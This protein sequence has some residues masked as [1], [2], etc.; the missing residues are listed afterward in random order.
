MTATARP[1]PEPPAP[2]ARC[3]ASNGSCTAVLASASATLCTGSYLGD[4]TTCGAIS[5]AAPTSPANTLEDISLTG[6]IVALSSPDDGDA[7][8]AL[9][10]PF[11]FYGNT[12][13]GVRV[14]SNGYLSFGPSASTP[15]NQDPIPDATTPNDGI[16]ALWDDLHL[17]VVGHVFSE[18]RG[19]APYRRFI[20]QWNRVARFD[21]PAIDVLVYPEDTFQV[22]LYET[23]NAVEFRYGALN[24]TTPW[25]ATVGL[26]N[27][28]GTLATQ[29]PQSVV[30]GGN[31]ALVF[32][33]SGMTC[34]QP[35][36]AAAPP[37]AASSLPTPIAS[38]PAVNTRAMALPAPPHPAP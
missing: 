33:P 1:A 36:G 21:D 18:T 3:S 8:V 2:P 14:G 27:S 28:T 12:K 25:T 31:T 20:V 4:G 16:Y 11:T 17:H 24:S 9:P 22:I 34:P 19:V 35:T 13:T 7:A 29:V 10:F 26:E 37:R 15:A 38:L 6:T 23:A 32:V 5:Y 30:T